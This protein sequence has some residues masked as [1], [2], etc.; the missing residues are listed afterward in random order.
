MSRTRARG[1]RPGQLASGILLWAYV[2]LLA[3]VWHGARLTP[4]E[5]V[6]I[7]LMAAILCDLVWIPLGLIL[8]SSFLHWV[9]WS[10][11]RPSGRLERLAAAVTAALGAAAIVLGFMDTAFVLM[12]I[13]LPV[14]LVRFLVRSMRGGRPRAIAQKMTIA[15]LP[16]FLILLLTGLHYGRQLIPVRASAHAASSLRV[17]T[18][19]IYSDGDREMRTRAAEEIRREAPDVLFLQELRSGECEFFFRGELGDLYP[20]MLTTAGRVRWAGDIV[21]IMSRYPL[22]LFSPEGFGSGEADI[23]RILF[24]VVETEGGRICVAC[25][26]LQ[27]GG[28]GLEDAAR[29][30]LSPGETVEQISPMERSVETIRRRHA[31]WLTETAAATGLPVILAGDFNDTPSSRVYR[32]LDERMDNAFAVRGWGLGSTFGES[33]IVGKRRLREIPLAGFLA[34]DL[35]RIDHVFVSRDLQ[36]LSARVVRDALGSDHKPVVVDI[37]LDRLETHR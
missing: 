23:R 15:H 28:R 17:M 29:R 30:R 34:R 13:P 19:N 16:L 1:V 36:V 14:F 32:M 6:L 22:T 33:W 27:S 2:L 20:H 25:V 37:G 8:W 24:A 5:A 31:A 9:F 10:I 3:F 35:L 12:S 11:L 18:Y 26:H 4:D 7:R 21:A